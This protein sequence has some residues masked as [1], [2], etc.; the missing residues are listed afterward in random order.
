[1]RVTIQEIC[2]FASAIPTSR[3]FTCG[4][5]IIDRSHILSCD[6]VD[7]SDD[8][9]VYQILTFCLQTTSLKNE[10]HEIN[11]I[12]SKVGEIIEMECSYQKCVW[13]APHKLALEKYD[14][15]FA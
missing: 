5:N 9:D 13:S 1:M 3:N 4:E 14:E 6:K 8:R 7:N 12:I 15:T 11:G 2:L 10:P